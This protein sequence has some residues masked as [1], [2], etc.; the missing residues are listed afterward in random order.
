MDKKKKKKRSN[1][2]SSTLQECLVPYDELFTLV[3]KWRKY[4]KHWMDG[5]FT[6]LD[7]E[8]IDVETEEL[9]R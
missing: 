6:S 1:H 3:M 9:A 4:E 5:D 7:P 8:F 2:P